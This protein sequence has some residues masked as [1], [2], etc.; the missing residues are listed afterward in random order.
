MQCIID[1]GNTDADGFEHIWV[2]SD[3]ILL[4]ETTH[5]IDFYHTLD[6]GKLASHNP[7]LDGAQIGW[8]VFFFV[9]LFRAY[10][11]L[12]NLPQSRGNGGHFRRPQ[13]IGDIAFCF[14]QVLPDQLPGKIYV[15][16]FLENDR[17]DR[18]P[19]AGN[20][21][22]LDQLLDILEGKLNRGGDELLYLLCGQSRGNGDD[23]HL[24]VGDVGHGING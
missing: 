1:I 17:H 10:H 14:F 6:A 21:A 19:E 11:V 24:V 8:R 23:L 7:V 12:V 22:Y 2:H 9:P 13:P 16:L 3:F 4:E 18:Q 15:H 20:R 5:R